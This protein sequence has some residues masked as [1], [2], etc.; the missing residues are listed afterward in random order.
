MLSQALQPN[1][2][3]TETNPKLRLGIVE[4]L[5]DTFSTIRASRVCTCAM[6]IMAEYSH[7]KEEIL[8]SLKVRSSLPVVALHYKWRYSQTSRVNQRL[9]NRLFANCR[10]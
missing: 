5:R 9:Y 7:S 4:R 1:R 2:E 3:I 6:W 8:E 10:V